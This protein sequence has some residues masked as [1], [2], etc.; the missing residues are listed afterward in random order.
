MAL[1]QDDGL[2]PASLSIDDFYLTRK[3]QESLAHKYA[4][5]R[6]LQTRG[7]AMTH[8]LKLGTQTLR[9]LR[10]A[11][12]HSPPVPLPRY[13]KSAYQGKG[14]R[15]DPKTWPTVQGPV[16]VVLFEGWMLGFSPVSSAAAAAVD[17]DLVPVNQSL[18]DYKKAWD[19][20]VSSWLVVRVADPSF[21]HKWRLQAEH[22]MRAAGQDAMTDEEVAA[23]VDR[24]MP[25]YKC[26]LSGL[27]RNGPT[28][29]RTGS[30]L[31]V[32]VDES[33]SPIA[34]QPRPIM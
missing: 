15:A 18:A 26:Y 9:A 28:T 3:D 21:A 2:T 16:D 13:N 31:V 30:L 25:A 24:F 23:F 33:R 8:D 6:L 32:E 20:F 12:A 22:A 1:L 10:N 4:G 27:Y 5:N 19:D 14:D 29:A 11:K 7:N 34:K 17:P